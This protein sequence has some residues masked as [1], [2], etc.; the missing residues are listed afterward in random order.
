MKYDTDLKVLLNVVFILMYPVLVIFSGQIFPPISAIAFLSP[1][2]GKSTGLVVGME[3]VLCKELGLL[4][5]ICTEISA[6]LFTS[7]MTLENLPNILVPQL[8]SKQEHQCLSYRF[9]VK[10]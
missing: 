4:I 5:Q 6:S 1:N 8:F 9:S 7:C 3:G 2:P 10:I